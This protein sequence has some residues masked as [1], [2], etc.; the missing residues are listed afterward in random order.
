[1]ARHGIINSCVVSS[2]VPHGQEEM[3]R[4][5]VAREF[6]AEVYRQNSLNGEKNVKIY[7]S[8]VTARQKRTLAKEEFNNQVDRTPVS[9]FPQH[10][11]PGPMSS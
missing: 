8:H 5:L 1:M 6:G 7:M 4:K 10:P 9:L 11:C 2:D 3:T